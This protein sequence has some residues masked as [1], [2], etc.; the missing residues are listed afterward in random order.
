MIGL[1]FVIGGLSMILPQ[2]LFSKRLKKIGQHLTQAKKDS[3]ESISDF[4]KGMPTIQAH[5]V[6]P[7]FIDET[8]KSILTSEQFQFR[9]YQTHHLVMFWT[10][11][12][13][14]IGLILPFILGIL[15]TSL[16]LTTLI[17]MMTAA[18]YLIS[19]LQQLLEAHAH[20]QSSEPIRDKLLTLSKSF[21]EKTKNKPAQHTIVQLNIRQLSKSFADKVI[22][23]DADLSVHSGQHILITGPSGCGKTTF[24]RLLTGEDSE[25]QG[26]IQFIDDNGQA[27]SP[28]F[29]DIALI[30]QNPCIFHLSLRENI[31]LY[32]SVSDFQLENILKKVQLWENIQER[33][34]QIV[35][36]EDLS[37][38]Q[39][40]RIEIARALLQG[41]NILLADEITASLDKETAE[42]IRLVLQQLPCTIIE[43][44]HHFDPQNYQ[45]IFKIEKGKLVAI[46]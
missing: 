16:S 4:G 9:Y 23:K 11:P 27:H 33:L 8:Q 6:E 32:Q 46:K 28:S 14:G 34:D 43:I 36:P 18:T 7:S 44:A 22:F 37:G 13:K 30:R 45:N 25:F 21:P 31:C 29:N 38:G 3:L 5:Q 24:L 17:A 2:F 15:T 19:P 1:C 39:M 20:L 41:K 12:L 35:S 10:G 26:Q 42:E 40:M